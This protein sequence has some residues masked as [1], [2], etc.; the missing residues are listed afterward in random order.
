MNENPLF[1]FEDQEIISESKNNVSSKIKAFEIIATKSVYQKQP[2]WWLGQKNNKEYVRE[3]ILCETPTSKA[4]YNKEIK[5]KVQQL[6]SADT[7]NYR[8]HKR[9]QEENAS[10]S[11][12][13]KLSSPELVDSIFKD[14]LNENLSK[15]NS[16]LKSSSDKKTCEKSL[17]KPK[18]PPKPKKLVKYNEICN[19]AI[20]NEQKTAIKISQTY[21]CLEEMKNDFNS[22]LVYRDSIGSYILYRNSLYSCG[23]SS[24]KCTDFNPS[25]NIYEEIV[26]KQKANVQS[27]CSEASV[28]S[29]SSDLPSKNRT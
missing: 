13:N 20:L 25:T 18:L 5:L 17:I 12:S 8:N 14:H 6:Y 10:S 2:N 24:H 19:N 11:Q 29:I 9:T 1:K 7:K 23:P 21:D 27:E 4:V 3:S 15:F 22:K 28:Y 26:Y 16:N